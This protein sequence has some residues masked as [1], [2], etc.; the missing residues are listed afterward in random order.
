MA[1]VRYML[2]LATLDPERKRAL[3]VMASAAEL[4]LSVATNAAAALHWLESHDPHVIVF[5]T[6]LSKSEKLCERVR[7]KKTLATVPI[8]GLSSDLSDAFTAKLFGMGADDVIPLGAKSSLMH[9][10]RAVP[11]AASL[12]PP[13]DRGT[14]VVADAERGRCDV[15]GRVLS[16]AGYDVKHAYDEAAA[17]FW[18]AKPEVKVVVLNADLVAPR[19]LIEQARK[20]GGSAVWVVVAQRRDLPAQSEAFEGAPGIAV[21][22][23][24]A[25]PEDVLFASNEMLSR[26]KPG[27]LRPRAL[28]GTGVL[29]RGAGGDE[30]DFG[31]SYNVSSM[32]IYVR[33]LAP[34]EADT[35]WLELRP[36]RT[37]KRVRLA[38]RVAWRRPFGTLFGSTVPPGFGVEISGGLGED[39]ALWTEACAGLAPV[40]SLPGAVLEKPAQQETVEIVELESI[41]PESVEEV[42]E[43]PKPEALEEVAAEPKPEPLAATPVIQLNELPNPAAPYRP[44]PSAG[45]PP[46]DP[47]SAAWSRKT[48]F[49]GSAVD[50]FAPE[51]PLEASAALA[52]PESRRSDPSLDAAPASVKPAPRTAVPQRSS[53]APV[54]LALALMGTL[55]GGAC[56]FGVWWTT[57]QRTPVAS[58]AHSPAPASSPEPVATAPSIA[59]PAAPQTAA[60]ATVTS[61]P[62][63]AATPPSASV[64]APPAP[65]ASAPDDGADGTDLLHNQGYLT[66]TSSAEADVYATGFKIGRTN[67]K[68]KSRC[69]LRYV[70]LGQG[71]PPRWISPGITVAVKCQG[72]TSV[73]LEPGDPGPVER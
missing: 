10:L 32:G 37:N 30:D 43:E 73:A 44:S 5:D 3:G 34:P 17:R 18:S 50:V 57:R 39:A 61:S 60:P 51:A 53:K 64:S 36:P 13:P 20:Q 6:N 42:A 38:G 33:T 63:V 41:P 25:P 54:V 59:P 26:E 1:R 4:E 8:I 67:Q 62:S 49:V 68:N 48:P 15:L 22:G 70:R 45:A 2:C 55:I 21:I 58:A 71:D 7:S 69:Y 9:R 31:F 72:L 12:Y 40:R 19:E 66:V 23:V 52:P 27:R 11:Q 65:A 46:M 29:F 16:N 14:A 24:F 47:P 35:V 28:Y 56:A